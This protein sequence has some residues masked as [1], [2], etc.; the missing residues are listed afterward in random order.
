MGR[1]D[2]DT[3][4]LTPL[5]PRAGFAPR[6]RQ[7]EHPA[8]KYRR[9]T[10][11]SGWARRRSRAHAIRCGSQSVGRASVG[12]GARVRR[13][14]WRAATTGGTCGVG[15]ASRG[16]DGHGPDRAPRSQ[17]SGGPRGR[18]PTRRHGG[19]R[20]RSGRPRGWDSR[21]SPRSRTGRVA[22]RCPK[23]QAGAHGSRLGASPA[24]QRR[25]GRCTRAARPVSPRR[26]RSTRRAPTRP[27]L[28]TAASARSTSP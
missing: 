13:L 27:G 8:T 5:R 24:G 10:R 18:R 26:P 15:R 7:A 11:R 25:S 21:R 28:A 9:G 14:A 19:E 4:P 6:L 12:S 23:A 22:S 1:A 17:P 2:A 16:E 3:G 20:G